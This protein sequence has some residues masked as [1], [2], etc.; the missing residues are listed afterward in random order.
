MVGVT[1]GALGTR[2]VLGIDRQGGATPADLAVAALSLG[3]MLALSVWG[4][5]PLRMY[6]ALIGMAVGY[7]AAG[8]AGSLTT[9][10]LGR[11]EAAPLVHF[12]NLGH[13]GWSFDLGLA[14]PFAVAALTA[15][16]RSVGDI[17]TCQKINDAEWT[18]PD[19]P[20]VS[21]GVLANGLGTVSAGLLG[22]PGVNVLTSGVGLTGATGVT[23][24]RIAYWI[25]GMFIAL[26]FLP[27]AAALFAIMPRPVIGAALLFSACAVLVNGLQIITSRMLDV[28]R[29]FVIGLSFLIGLT[30]DFY[31]TF[32]RGLPTTIQPLAGSSLVLG[33]LTALFLNLVFRIGV[34]RTERTVVDPTRPDAKVL[35]DFMEVHGAAWGARRDV[36]DRASFNLQQSI[37]TIVEGCN[38]QGPLE[39]EASF[40][41]F[42]LD[43][44]VSYDGP[45]LELPDRRPTNEEI[46]ASEEGHR[47]LAGFLLR[48]HADRVQS[49]HKAG[50]STVLFHFDH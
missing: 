33:T 18:R 49:S 36:V 9:A 27:K 44:R 5:G 3:T 4:K 19:L 38:P 17:T 37:E 39:V 42:N 12:P 31:P 29:T 6:S 30:V 48:R 14:I 45:P 50:R 7:F 46:M 41:E 13:A 2:N 47:R 1:L 16:I 43:L 11:F 25:G 20:S 10:D 35:E 8:A 40:D 28:R 15:S 22:T 26:A 23:S 24:R 32:F 34:R 21:G